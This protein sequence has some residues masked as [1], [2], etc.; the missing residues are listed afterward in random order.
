M[1]ADSDDDV[2]TMFPYAP[3]VPGALHVAPFLQCYKCAH[4]QQTESDTVLLSGAGQLLGRKTAMVPSRL[5]VPALGESVS[6]HVNL[7]T[8]LVYEH[9]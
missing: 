2:D 5:N 9:R 3:M 1:R 7:P 6:R 4:K 8:V